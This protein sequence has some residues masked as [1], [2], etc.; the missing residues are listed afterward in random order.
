MQHCTN[1]GRQI[2]PG[3]TV[4]PN[5]R[6]NI[7]PTP[8]AHLN[9]QSAVTNLPSQTPAYLR[10]AKKPSGPKIHTGPQPTYKHSISVITSTPSHTQALDRHRI[11]SRIIITA[12]IIL[13]MFL[14]ISEAGLLYYTEMS[15]SEQLHAQSTAIAQK[16]QSA[17]IHNTAIARVRATAIARA[18]ATKSAIAEINAKKTAVAQAQATSTTLQNIYT[19][20]TSEH[21]VLDTSL[22]NN[23]SAKWDIYPTKDGGGCTFTKNALHSKAFQTNYYSPCLAHATNFHNFAL[24]IQMT[25]LKGDEGGI[26][27]RSNSHDSDFYSLRVRTDGTYGLILTQNDGH[28]TPLVY[29]KSDLIKTGIGHPNIIT[30]IAQGNIFYLYM[31]KHYVGSASDSSY[32]SGSIGVMAVDRKNKTDVA[33]NN[34]RVWKL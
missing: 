34:L 4:C 2:S 5:C 1:C 20:S 3:M 9:Y 7:P 16:V 18:R 10:A 13:T 17:T 33:F 31:N 23:T 8:A 11:F 24:E 26:I 29:D 32:S 14:I 27:F 30:I 28:T 21:T 15:H 22:F 6:Q 12:I 19:R 25:I